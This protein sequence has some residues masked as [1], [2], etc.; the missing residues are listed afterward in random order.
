MMVKQL[1]NFKVMEEPALF[2]LILFYFILLIYLTGTM[3]TNMVSKQNLPLKCY[4]KFIEN[5]SFRLQSLVGCFLY[6]IKCTTFT[7]S[8]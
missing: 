8:I 3:Q 2:S 4:L 5:A 1:L 7:T 6:T